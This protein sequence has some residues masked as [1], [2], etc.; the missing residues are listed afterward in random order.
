MYDSGTTGGQLRVMSGELLGELG[1]WG[2]NYGGRLSECKFS[3]TGTI[4]LCSFRIKISKNTPLFPSHRADRLLPVRNQDP[5]PF[6]ANS[7]QV[8]RAR[9]KVDR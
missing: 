8:V 7:L 9:H 6:I 4:S 1:H 2:T 5:R 3:R